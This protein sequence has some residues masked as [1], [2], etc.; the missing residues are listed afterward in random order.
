MIEDPEDPLNP[1]PNWGNRYWKTLTQTRDALGIDKHTSMRD[2]IQEEYTASAKAVNSAVYN[3]TQIQENVL[4]PKVRGKIDSMDL[5]KEQFATQSA[6]V[7]LTDKQNEKQV[8]EI[9]MTEDRVRITVKSEDQRMLM[10]NEPKTFNFIVERNAQLNINAP[11][12]GP[13]A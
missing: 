8:D 5:Q 4:D 10:K 7:K 12:Q 11:S 2:M 9:V 1:I 3:E 6:H 13:Q